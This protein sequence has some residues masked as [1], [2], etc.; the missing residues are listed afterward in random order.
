M[1]SNSKY[2]KQA[3][4]VIATGDIDYSQLGVALA[5]ANPRLFL[6]LLPKP[7]VVTH[8]SWVV[9]AARYLNEGHYVDA[10]RSVRAGTLMGLKAAKDICDEVRSEAHSDNKYVQA[11]RAARRDLAV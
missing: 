8:D 3:I 1:S 10:I 5:K 9:E 6:S 2:Y 4:D 7:V 11:I